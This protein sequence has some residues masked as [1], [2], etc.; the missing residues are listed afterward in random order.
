MGLI[1]ICVFLYLCFSLTHYS[2]MQSIA[3]CSCLCASVR[4]CVRACVCVCVCVCVL[5]L[6][7][8]VNFCACGVCSRVFM[9][10]VRFDFYQFDKPD[11]VTWSMMVSLARQLPWLLDFVG[12]KSRLCVCLCCIVFDWVPQSASSQ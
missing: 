6:V 1:C 2:P 12:T 8:R 7:Q 5:C 11:D 10:C 4:A 9:Y 3:L